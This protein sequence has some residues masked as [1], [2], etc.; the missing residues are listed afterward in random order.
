MKYKLIGDYIKNYAG[1]TDF[2]II[3]NKYFQAKR[4]ENLHYNENLDRV[5]ATV[6]DREDYS[7]FVEMSDFSS[8]C[9]CKG[10]DMN[11]ICKHTVAVL[12]AI[13]EMD[14]AGSFGGSVPE[15]EVPESKSEFDKLIESFYYGNA[16]QTKK[17]KMEVTFEIDL[18][19]VIAYNTF[20]ISLRL[21]EEQLYMVKNI[22][23]FI[24]NIL[25]RKIIDFGKKFI[26]KPDVHE[27][28]DVDQRLINLLGRMYETNEFM[29]RTTNKEAQ[30]LLFVEKKALIAP[31]F[32]DQLIEILK[33]KKFAL[34]INEQE[35]G[36]RQII[37]SKMPIE[38]NLQEKKGQI[39]VEVKRDPDVLQLTENGQLFLDR[40]NNVVTVPAEEARKLLPIS[41]YLAGENEKK[42]IIESDKKSFMMSV[43]LPEAKNLGRVEIHETLK[44]KIII[45]DLMAKMYLDY[46]AGHIVAKLIFEYGGLEYNAFDSQEA[47][48]AIIQDRTVVRDLP[49]EQRI[50]EFVNSNCFELIGNQLYIEDD[51][52]IVE[53]A[54][55]GVLELQKFADVYCSESFKSIRVRTGK[56]ISTGLRFE[57]NSKLLQF[58]F[59]IE[60]LDK[61][62][63]PDV[64]EAM[65]SQKKYFKLN[66]GS[67]LPLDLQELKDFMEILDNL[68]IK[69]RD[70]KKEIIELPQYRAFYLNSKLEE[71]Q[72]IHYK[73]GLHIKE[74]MMEV[75]E[76]EDLKF[77]MPVEVAGVLRDYQETGINWLKTLSKFKFG[78]ILADDMG[79]GKTLQ[80]LSYIKSDIEEQGNKPSLIVAPT[81]LVYNWQSEI[82]KFIPTLKTKI[83]SGS[84]PLREEALSSIED[85][86][87]VIT[88]YPLLRRDIE[89]YE[90]MNFRHCII[91]EAQHIKN[92]GSQTSKAVKIIKAEHRFAL[93]G[94]PIENALSDLWS[95]FDFVMPGYLSNYSKF[96]KKFEYPII[97]AGSQDAMDDL[98]KHIDPFIIRRMKADVLDELP[99]KIEN[100]VVVE[101]TDEQKEVYL[102]CLT[103][104]KADIDKEIQ[105]KGVDKSKIM[106]LAA[107]T[108]LR[109]ICCDPALI[110]DDYKGESAKMNLL[111]ELVDEALEGGH[112]ILLF[113]QFTTMLKRIRKRIEKRGY[114]C[115]YLDGSTDSKD[116]HTMVNRFNDGEKNIFLI[117][118]KAGGTG[119]NLTGADMVIHFD[120]WWNP[121][122]EEQATDRA[123]RIGQD[124]VVHVIK[125]ITKGTIEEKIYELQQRKKQLIDNVI[126]PGETVLSK[127]S[128]D[129]LMVLFDED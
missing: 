68:D 63:L 89:L 112:R 93:T 123:Y 108:R 28:E 11:G 114:S 34:V 7:V 51:E 94:T 44:D 16:M 90:H 49:R 23:K 38:F 75:R 126:K 24:E 46:E 31:E 52:E 5:I 117:S 118:L 119:L 116:R 43:L 77:E 129:E 18:M 25:S 80:V 60:G 115:F 20:R 30:K 109:Q 111:D 120:P 121:A 84:K 113:S 103:S 13:K 106:I 8:Y 83:I 61:G 81:S 67:I 104:V 91:D 95:I 99:G 39:E 21:G 22:E 33:D 107:L 48:S 12:L 36:E 27:F 78:G 102:G 88:S 71:L 105:Q 101:L 96:R 35:L 87:I 125:M 76:P 3:G 26:Y 41:K 86:D 1:G 17:L 65:R 45:N 42:A 122:V 66:D 10:F 40:Y 100:E 19:K 128:N 69:K 54:E 32:L 72:G 6:C 70:L 97:R 73:R 14:E 92:Q 110:M 57:L 82:A 62:H 124:K 98:L 74:F 15:V 127:L 29:Y 4:V 2:Y 79:L 58:E 53:F 56:V 9:E 50:I 59:S 47:I 55:K 37:E 64:V 85:V